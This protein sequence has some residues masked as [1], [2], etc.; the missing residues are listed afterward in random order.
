M[1]MVASAVGVLVSFLFWNSWAGFGGTYRWRELY[2]SDSGGTV[3]EQ[4]HEVSSNILL[5]LPAE[6]SGHQ[7]EVIAGLG[8]DSVKWH[9]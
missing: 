1:L 9:A 8:D 4:H 5:A 2:R 7:A 3:V 6:G